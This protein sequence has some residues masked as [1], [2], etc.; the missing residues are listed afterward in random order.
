MNENYAMSCCN[1]VID[2]K[3][4]RVIRTEAIYSVK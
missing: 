1:D 4:I 3:V 2:A